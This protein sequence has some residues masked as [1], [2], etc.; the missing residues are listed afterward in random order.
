ME[1]INNFILTREFSITRTSLAT[2]TGSFFYNEYAWL[3]QSG[4]GNILVLNDPSKYF[5]ISFLA[6]SLHSLLMLLFPTSV[7]LASGLT[8]TEL[9]YKDWL[10]YIW[11]FILI[12][13]AL[14]I[15]ISIILVNFL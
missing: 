3:M 15:I 14:I 4:F 11:K 6:G 2:V 5:V 12:I 9:E 1:T 7:L 8:F 10:K 13:L